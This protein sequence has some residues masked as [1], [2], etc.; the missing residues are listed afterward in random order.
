VVRLLVEGTDG[1]VEQFY[2]VDGR[3]AVVR[4]MGARS[5]VTLDAA[6]ALSH[7]PAGL[8]ERAEDVREDAPPRCR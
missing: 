2:G 6:A 8:I 4:V 7:P 3:L 5:F 1:R